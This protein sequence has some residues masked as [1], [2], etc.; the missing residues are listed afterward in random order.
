M[1]NRDSKGR[2]VKG[3]RA[4]KNNKGG[5]PRRETEENYL[6]LTVAK[7]TPDDWAD[8]VC[9]AVKQAIG[10]DS[11]ARQWLGDILIGKYVQADISGGYTESAFME[12]LS[13]TDEFLSPEH[14]EAYEENLRALSERMETK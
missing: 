4:A 5:R 11:R 10:G 2:F 7:V 3:N 12:L 6:K 14:R 8:I 13:M 1:A 9:R